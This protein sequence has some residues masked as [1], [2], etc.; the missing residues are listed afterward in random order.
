M[1]V[2]V[3]PTLHLPRSRLVGALIAAPVGLIEAGGG[4][5][6]STGSAA[7]ELVGQ[8]EHVGDGEQQL[9]RGYSELLGFAQRAAAADRSAN[10]EDL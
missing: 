7:G 9:V 10:E 1:S 4:Y 6:K 8:V 2:P 3:L 5:G